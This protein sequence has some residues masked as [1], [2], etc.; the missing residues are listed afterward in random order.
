MG[1]VYEAEDLKLQRHVV[2]NSFEKLKRKVPRGRS[3][4]AMIRQTMSHQCAKSF[5][6]KAGQSQD[7]FFFPF[8]GFL[9]RSRAASVAILP[10]AVFY[11]RFSLAARWA[12]S[13]Q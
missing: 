7:G 1:V 2:L 8:C 3:E 9:L 6:E 12:S 13:I 11:E 4:S 10:S 5:H